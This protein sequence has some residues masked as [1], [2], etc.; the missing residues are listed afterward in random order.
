MRRA[1]DRVPIINVTESFNMP[2]IFFTPGTAAGSTICAAYLL[3]PPI[4]S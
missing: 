1:P 3:L 4:F 2:A